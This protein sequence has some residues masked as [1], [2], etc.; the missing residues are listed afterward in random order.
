MNTADL[1]AFKVQPLV[2]VV[3]PTRLLLQNIE[4]RFVCDLMR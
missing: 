3:K 4:V 1:E 2:R